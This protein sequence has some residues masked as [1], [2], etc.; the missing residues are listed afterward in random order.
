M[1]KI[2]NIFLAVISAAAILSGAA[3]CTNLDEHV[4]SSLTPENLAGTEE[5]TAE[6][7]FDKIKQFIRA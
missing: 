4:Y 5:E 6:M 1:K 3:A 2:K 7:I